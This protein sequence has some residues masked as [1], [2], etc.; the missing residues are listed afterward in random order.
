MLTKTLDWILGREPVAT[1]TGLA[2]IVTAT[3]GLLYAFDVLRLSPEQVAAVGT[4]LAV[5]AGWAARQ[6]VS[7]VATPVERRY[8]RMKEKVAEEVKSEQGLDTVADDSRID[9]AERQL[10]RGEAGGVFVALAIAAACVIVLV[11]GF[12][13]CGD[14]LFED[15]Q[16]RNDLGA[17]A[18]T[19][20][21][22]EEEEAPPPDDG[23]GA[24]CAAF[25]VIACGDLIVPIPDVPGGGG[26]EK[27]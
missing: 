13:L 20:D 5:V 4:F 22:E 23:D 21:H 3:F 17:P 7:P 10:G 18:W 15:E 26:G 9:D 2:G 27:A 24:R 8:E 12:A 14:A 11:G 6:A 1:A 25:V 19:A 16:E